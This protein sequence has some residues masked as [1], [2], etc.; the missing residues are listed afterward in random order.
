MKT[1]VVQRKTVGSLRPGDLL[2]M[3][4]SVSVRAGQAADDKTTAFLL[5]HRCTTVPV[6][7]GITD[8]QTA[9]DL[10]PRLQ[11]PFHALRMRL[12]E[13]LK[14]I[15]TP[16]HETE[17]AFCAKGKKKQISD[18]IL[19]ERDP[20]PLY[21]P[22]I[23]AGSYDLL[24]PADLT[25]L[26][27]E[28]SQLYD[29]LERMTYRGPGVKPG[30]RSIPRVHFDSIRVG[31]QFQGERVAFVGDALPWHCVDTAIWFMVAMIN[32]NK[33]RLERG[34]PYSDTRFDPNSTTQIT[35][36]VRYR[37]EII[38]S[39]ALGIL[40][41]AIGFAHRDVHQLLCAMWTRTLETGRYSTI[42][43]IA[44]SDARLLQKQYFAVRN[45]LRNRDDIPPVA[46]MM[47]NLQYDYPDTC[48]YPAPFENRF[49]H[50]FI[51]MFHIIDSYDTLI[52][53]VYPQQPAQ[54]Q[55][56]LEY[57]RRNAGSYVYSPEG[58]R[59]TQRFDFDLYCRWLHIMAP[60]YRYELLHLCRPEDPDTP[61][62]IVQVHSYS[63][64]HLPVFS[65][66]QD[67]Q[68]RRYPF[69]ALLLSL[70]HSVLMSIR[71]GQVTGRK[72]LDWAGD[73]VVREPAV[74]TSPV[75]GH[76][77]YES[78]RNLSRNTSRL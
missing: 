70:E 49:L 2:L 55:M 78:E 47:V 38:Q 19:F 73:L 32:L 14:N 6:V 25:S 36:E 30:K 27:Q 56:A 44:Q 61:L 1:P 12:V 75:E 8:Q 13:K 4:A 69:G 59:P 46:R 65:V 39:A 72:K 11:G 50:E 3:D 66:R 9:A 5:R 21:Q 24:T 31:T 63:T 62:Y 37:P 53:P 22:D 28:L 15:Y 26:Q 76:P 51:R 54:K 29:G 45:L 60:Y 33:E 34:I 42:A 43:D 16:Y 18:G 41:H 57:I 40:L 58:Y 67:Q 71:D 35:D 77:L 68:Q 74:G 17:T 20:G 52:N 23:D 10:L 7:Q 64:S 48:G